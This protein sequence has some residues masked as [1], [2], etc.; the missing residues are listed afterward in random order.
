MVSALPL[1]WGAAL[2]AAPFFAHAQSAYPAKSVR[3][4]IGFPAGSSS[5]VV[6]RIMAEQ[7]ATRLGQRGVIENRGIVAPELAAKSAPDGYTLLMGIND[8]AVTD[9]KMALTAANLTA[10]GVIKLSMGKKKHVLLKPA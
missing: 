4:I 9:E 5:D 6:G 8:V 2:L 10:D 7:L 1:L 3:M